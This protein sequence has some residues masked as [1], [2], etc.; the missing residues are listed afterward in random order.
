MQVEQSSPGNE[1]SSPGDV[2]AAF[3][4]LTGMEA[5]IVTPKDPDEASE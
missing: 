5:T 2:A 1:A 4:V 3:A